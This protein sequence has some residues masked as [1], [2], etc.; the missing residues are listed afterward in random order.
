LSSKLALHPAICERL[1][2]IIAPW[3]LEPSGRPKLQ[4]SGGATKSLPLRGLH[5]HLA[6]FQCAG[7]LLPIHRLSICSCALPGGPGIDPLAIASNENRVNQIK[8]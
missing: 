2:A 8:P 1:G 5:P 6:P 7:I 4:T 3:L